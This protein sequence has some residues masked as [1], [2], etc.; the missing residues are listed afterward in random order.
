MKRED[1]VTVYT[2]KVEKIV[3]TFTNRKIEAAIIDAFNETIGGLSFGNVVYLDRGRA[4]GVEMGTVFEIFS[5]IDAG[6]GKKIS[7]DPTFKIVEDL[8]NFVFKMSFI[9]GERSFSYQPNFSVGLFR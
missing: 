7:P 4:D 8:L 9:D 1:R 5:F 6:T 3:Q 2:P